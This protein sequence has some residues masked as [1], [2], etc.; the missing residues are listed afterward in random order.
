VGEEIAEKLDMT[1]EEYRR[2]INETGGAVMAQESSGSPPGDRNE[3]LENMTEQAPNPF[4]QLRDEESKAIL[5]EAIGQLPER[6]KAVIVLY[7]YEGL[8]FLE[9]GKILR[10]SESRVS[11]IHSEVLGQLKLKLTGAL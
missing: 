10:V 8:K 1:V 9:I 4:E 11:Q 7:Y 2:F 6:D 3:I 5:V